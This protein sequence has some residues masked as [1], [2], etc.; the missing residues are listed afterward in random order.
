MKLRDLPVRRNFNEFGFRE[1]IE[2]FLSSGEL[3]DI[4]FVV[5]F[6][7]IDELVYC[8]VMQHDASYNNCR[9]RLLS[10]FNTRTRGREETLSALASFAVKLS[11]GQGVSDEIISQFSFEFPM[12]AGCDENILFALIHIRHRRSLPTGRELI[13]P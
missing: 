3:P 9:F 12:A 6:F 4:W 13:F 1:F 5:D 8:F 10:A 11:L 7:D 2:N